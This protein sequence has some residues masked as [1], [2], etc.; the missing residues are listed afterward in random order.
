MGVESGVF[1]PVSAGVV[2]NVIPG[3]PVSAVVNA[4]N[5]SGVPVSVVA[6]KVKDVFDFC[7]RSRSRTQ[8]RKGTYQSL[9]FVRQVHTYRL[10]QT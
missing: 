9:R 4:E 3:V 7:S 2:M 8:F 5:V 6:V 10:E 1:A